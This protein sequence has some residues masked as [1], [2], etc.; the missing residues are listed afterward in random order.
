MI[1]V[2]AFSG[3]SLSEIRGL[4]WDDYDGEFLHVR[5]A[6]WRSAIGEPKTEARRQSVP[7][8]KPLREMLDGY[9]AMTPGVGWIFTNA[10]GRPAW[11]DNLALREIRPVIEAAGIRWH[12]WHAFRRGLATNL[13]HMGISEAIV[14]RILRHEKGSVVTRKHYIQTDTPQA[15]VAMKQFEEQWDA[16]GRQLDD[17]R[18]N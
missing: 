16:I 2:A 8:I 6:V 4:Q 15:V 5:R 7:V 13:Y 11:L 1:G 14:Q 10:K 9:K 17:K 3:L 12:G 18:V